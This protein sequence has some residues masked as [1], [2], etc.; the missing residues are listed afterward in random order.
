MADQKLSQKTLSMDAQFQKCMA[1]GHDLYQQ[2]NYKD[3]LA[4]FN[5]AV[6]H[7]PQNA[8]AWFYQAKSQAMCLKYPDCVAGC[9]KSLAL[10]P[11]KAETWFLKSF[12]HGVL[13]E[14]AQATETCT[15]GLTLNP[16]NKIMWYTRGQYLYAQGKLEEALQSFGNALK[17]SPDNEYFKEVHEKIK[18][19]LQRDGKSA[20][21]ANTVVAFLNQGGYQAALSAY[22][23]SLR[24]DPRGVNKAFQKDYALAH[25]ENPEKLLKDFEQTRVQERPH[26]TVELSQKE[27]EFGRETWVEASFCNQGKTTARDLSFHFPAEVKAKPLDVSPEQVAQLKASEKNINLDNVPELPAGNKITRLLS[28]TPTKVGQIALEVQT[29][30]TDIW[31]LKQLKTTVCWITV[32]KPGGQMPVIPGFKMLWRLSAGEE[33]NIYIAQ[34]TGEKSRLV[35][36]I[37]MTTPAQLS[38]ANEFLQEIKQTSKLMHPN[39]IRI[40]QYGEQPAPWIALEYMAKGTLKRRIGRLSI[41]EALQ[42]SIRLAD[43]L[44][45]ARNFRLA[46]RWITPDNIFFDERD[47][48]KLANW[49]TKPVTLK[50]CKNTPRD[51]V[52]PY[53][54]PEKLIEGVWATDFLADIYQLGAVLYEMLTGKP[55]FQTQGDELA[56]NIK[57]ALPP[58]PSTLNSGINKELD[59]I[60]LRCLTK[61][62]KE[63]YPTAQMLKTDLEAAARKFAGTGSTAK[64]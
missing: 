59:R 49:R 3:A 18:K 57:N 27:F 6:E 8:D 58:A 36:K 20:E 38:L 43:A 17:M 35:I 16:D 28:F 13:G 22:N 15:H 23:E 53:D 60:V 56:T 39:I 41:A 7:N 19:W 61:S 31:G 30:Y 63:R 5:T 55:P 48:P 1:E 2:H 44:A 21:W 25:L 29:D 62:R 50:L 64:A 51:N 52:T 11:E 33:T 14:Y 46:H 24:M 42:I 40:L 32:F 12:A 26:I 9:E 4:R 45:Y 37:L 34:R 47:T 10:N 54:P